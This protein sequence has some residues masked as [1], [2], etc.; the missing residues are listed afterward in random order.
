MTHK[1]DRRS[2]EVDGMELTGLDELALV[3]SPFLCAN[4]DMNSLCNDAQ[5]RNDAELHGQTDNAT[6]VLALR[7][8]RSH[9]I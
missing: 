6:R 1:R 5:A 4:F 2:C 7:P 9:L 8:I 3:S